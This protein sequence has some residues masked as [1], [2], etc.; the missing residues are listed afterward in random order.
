MGV[1]DVMIERKDSRR[2]FLNEKRR[3]GMMRK[4]AF[5]PLLAVITALTMVLVSCQQ[6]TTPTEKPT[7]TTTPTTTPTQ[8]VQTTTPTTTPATPTTTGPEKPKYGG[9]A[10]IA[11]T[12]DI[13][14]FDE[15]F[16]Q[17]TFA[18]TLHL[19][20]EELWQGDWARGPAGTGEANWIL[21][22][23]NNVDLKAGSLAERW[24]IPERGKI[25]FFIR[26]GVR[27]HN[28]PPT[29]GRELTVDDIVFS[30][31]RLATE[32]G[33]YI[34][35]GYPSLAASSIIT[36]DAKT[37]TVTIECP[38]AE[39]ANSV[40]LWPDYA[41]IMPQDAIKQFGNMN[42]WRNSIG[43]GPFILTDFVSNGSATFKKN[44]NFWEKN[45]VGPGKGDQLPYLDGVKL[46]IIT[47]TSTRMAAFRTGKLD[48]VG[49]EYDDVKDMLGN[50]NFSSIQ[51]I[52]DSCYEFYMRTDKPESPFSKKEVR[53]ALMLATDFKKI[54]NEYYDG[55]AE[56]LVWPVVNTKE[57][58]SAY[59]PLDKQPAN[60]QELYS[61]NPTKAKQLLT[62][63]GYPTGFKT[64]VIC[65]NTP[66]Q[67]DYLSMIKSMWAQVGIELT[68]DA[69][70]YAVWQG[71]LRLRQYDELIYGFNSGIGTFF[72]MINFRGTSQYNGSYVND[73]QVEEVY[74]AM[75]PFVG[76]DEE[77]LNKM[78][79]D[80]MPYVL[81]QAWVHPKPNPYSYVLWWPW[82]KNWHGELQVGYY[83]YPS[84]LKYRWQDVELKK[85]MTGQ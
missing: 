25:I 3:D 43:T 84:Y 16:V 12:A 61:Y 62:A 5:L 72:K 31:K 78:N 71:R 19:T 63:A 47:D 83:N 34:K 39:W 38:P 79:A 57:Y 73:P 23:I 41:E 67:V 9:V 52:A 66:T 54:V 2:P 55:K 77:K 32:T 15:L 35:L 85:K 27:W 80:L 82:V 29:N 26:K 58:A 64:T 17:H 53:Q 7:T 70:E 60:V 74:Q 10:T 36:G 6:T 24:E 65:Y 4:Q 49:G 22:G 20:N 56:M 30:L 45:P 59:L 33:S 28:K 21:G 40:T 14:G 18:Y 76:V 1:Q 50:P 8:P 69:R 11:L 75:Q 44:P 37:N 51:Y 13:L 81:E 68:I 42:D 48:G 46:L